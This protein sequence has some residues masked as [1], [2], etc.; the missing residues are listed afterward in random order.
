MASR[1]PSGPFDQLAEYFADHPRALLAL[2]IV[3][4]LV[5]VFFFVFVPLASIF[6]WSFW[7]VE[8][9]RLVPGFST[10]AYEELLGIGGLPTCRLDSLLKTLQIALTETTIPR[11][12]VLALASSVGTNVCGDRYQLLARPSLGHL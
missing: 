4:P 2:Q 12:T 11:A 7:T 3:P 5:F 9:N 8:N 10:S 1:R 6:A